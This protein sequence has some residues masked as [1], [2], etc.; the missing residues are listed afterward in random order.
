M[1]MVFE[2]FEFKKNLLLVSF[3]FIKSFIVTMY[4]TLIIGLSVNNFVF[5]EC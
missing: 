2:I 3:L 5:S 1:F 4:L